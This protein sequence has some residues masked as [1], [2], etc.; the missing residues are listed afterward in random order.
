MRGRPPPADPILAGIQPRWSSPAA[1]N[2]AS[3]SLVRPASPFP[4]PCFPSLPLA[5]GRRRCRRAL[6]ARPGRRLG[7]S[8]A[9]AFGQVPGLP[10]RLGPARGWPLLEPT[11]PSARPGPALGRT[12]RVP[13]RPFSRPGR[14][15]AGLSGRYCFPLFGFKNLKLKQFYLFKYCSKNCKL[16]MKLLSKTLSIV[17]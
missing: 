13:A 1:T 7:R 11:R 6:P 14:L 15:E 4:P 10:A 16:N 8:E 9:G 5:T 12:T 3:Y 17:W 2:H